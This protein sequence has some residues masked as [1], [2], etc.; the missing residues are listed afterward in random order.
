MSAMTALRNGGNQPI[1][2]DPERWQPSGA[3]SCNQAVLGVS[4]R[5]RNIPVF[6]Y[7]EAASKRGVPVSH[8]YCRNRRE[9]VAHRARLRHWIVPRL[10]RRWSGRCSEYAG[11][12]RV[13][14]KCGEGVLTFED[15]P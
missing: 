5:G 11:S 7:L 6:A 2:N 10:Q 3:C 15:M 9:G 4:N 8:S 12:W 13:S 14:G 1:S